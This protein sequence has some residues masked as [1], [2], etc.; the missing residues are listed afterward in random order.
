MHT[1]AA[2]SQGLSVQSLAYVKQNFLIAKSMARTGSFGIGVLIS[3]VL[4]SSACVT[5][6]RKQS[7]SIQ[8]RFRAPASEASPRININTASA[9]ELEKLPGIG[10]VMAERIIEHRTQ[11]GAFR[12][13]EHLMMVRGI[14]D[15]KFRALRELITVE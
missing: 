3:I 2:D 5:L 13:A 4:L 6:P 7:T 9:S 14:S 15:Q 8:P 10:K 11:Y 1:P 12:R